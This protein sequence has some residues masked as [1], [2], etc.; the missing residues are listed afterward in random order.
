MSCVFLCQ[1]LILGLADMIFQTP[2]LQSVGPPVVFS[3]GQAALPAQE[4]PCCQGRPC[5]GH[6]RLG[7]SLS[8]RGL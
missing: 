7:P 4:L 5:E 1:T 2:M 6:A 3:G 8:S